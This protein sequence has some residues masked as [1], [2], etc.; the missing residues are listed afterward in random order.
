MVTTRRALAGRH[1]VAV[2]AVVLAGPGRARA[3]GQVDELLVKLRHEDRA[4]RAMGAIGVRHLAAQRWG[5][6]LL[7]RTELRPWQRELAPA[8]PLLVEL[9][10]DDRG[11]EWIDQ[12]GTSQSV[13]TPRRE[14][15]MALLAL[16]R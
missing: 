1:L 11:L 3:A 9:L 8:V 6:A 7:T 16:E 4:T 15:S 2:A 10:E 5:F 14:A 12:D 13:T